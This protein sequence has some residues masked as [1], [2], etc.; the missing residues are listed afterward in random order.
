MRNLILKTLSSY[1]AVQTILD[2]F[3]SIMIN[4]FNFYIL[5]AMLV[6][7]RNLLP[8]QPYSIL[9]WWNIIANYS[10]PQLMKTVACIIGHSLSEMLLTHHK[11][12]LNYIFKLNSIPQLLRQVMRSIS[13]SSRLK[14]AVK[15]LIRWP[16]AG[17]DRPEICMQFLDNG[18]LR[19]TYNR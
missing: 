2:T 11:L 18:Y 12:E 1:W 17:Y 13:Y 7:K 5:S 19:L 9:A 6:K 4:I 16:G 10:L 15:T 8:N 3:Y 14:N